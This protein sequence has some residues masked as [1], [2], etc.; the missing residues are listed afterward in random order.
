[1]H[2]DYFQI[3]VILLRAKNLTRKTLLYV[4]LD[5]IQCQ[6]RAQKLFFPNVIQC[7]LFNSSE[8]DMLF[9]KLFC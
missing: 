3:Y 9:G 1:M 8:V 4:V 5:V 2:V 6:R 7:F